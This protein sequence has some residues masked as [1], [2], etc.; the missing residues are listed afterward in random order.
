MELEDSE[1]PETSHC[2]Q[3][4]TTPGQTTSKNGDAVG[5]YHCPS[6]IQR[7]EGVQAVEDADCVVAHL[8]ASWEGQESHEAEV[9]STGDLLKQREV[10][11]AEG[12]FIVGKL[13]RKRMHNLCK[14]C[15]K[16]RVSTLHIKH[17]ISALN[18]V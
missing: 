13:W 4:I 5:T 7:H 18:T 6:Q 9:I 14:C 2:L 1:S 8:V 11:I 16:S 15:P 17:I 12:Y 10:E 3:F